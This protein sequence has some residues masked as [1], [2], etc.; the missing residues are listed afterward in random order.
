MA[1]KPASVAVLAGPLV[2]PQGADWAAA[3][4]WAEGAPAGPPAGWPT[5]WAARMEVRSSRGGDLLARWHTSGVTEGV[6][7]P[8]GLSTYSVGSPSAVPGIADGGSAGQI[9]VS[10]SAAVSSAWTW[11]DSA[12]GYPFDLEL[13]NTVTGRV[14]RFLEGTVVLS[15]E[16]TTGA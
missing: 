11:G 8:V 12:R 2:I 14:V 16:V 7:G 15:R 4:L 13:V 5:Q 6:D 3:W 1:H 9:T 10:L